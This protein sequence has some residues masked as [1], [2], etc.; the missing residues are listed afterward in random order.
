MFKYIFLAIAMFSAGSFSGFKASTNI[1]EAKLAKVESNNAKEIAVAQKDRAAALEKSLELQAALN[2]KTTEIGNAVNKAVSSNASKSASTIAG[3]R[4][5]LSKACH[6]DGQPATSTSSSLSYGEAYSDGLR[7]GI[8]EGLE[9]R[10]AAP[11][12][13]QTIHLI[14]A[15]R[16]INEVCSKACVCS[17]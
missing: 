10:I 2:E 15:Q 3:L 4:S 1:Y 6:E 16:Y 5:A 11:A 17:N 8:A 12:T 7:N 14:G 9:R 13:I